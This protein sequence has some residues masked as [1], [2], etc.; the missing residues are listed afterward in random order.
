M[1]SYGMTAASHGDQEIVLSGESDR[2]RNIG[3][4]RASHDERRMPLM[5]CVVDG[6]LRIPRVLRLQDISAD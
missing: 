6:S 1:S 2:V 3:C 5:H 4:P